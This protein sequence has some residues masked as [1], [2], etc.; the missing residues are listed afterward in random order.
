MIAS[1]LIFIRGGIRS[2]TVPSVALI[3]FLLFGSKSYFSKSIEN[4]RP[5]LDFTTGVLRSKRTIQ[6]PTLVSIFSPR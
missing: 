2:S 5:F 6:F 4:M 3:K 1:F